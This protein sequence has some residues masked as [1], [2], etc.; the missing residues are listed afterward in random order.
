MGKSFC[1]SSP[2]ITSAAMYDFHDSRVGMPSLGAAQ[3]GGQINQAVAGDGQ[4][5]FLV[6]QQVGFPQGK[7][8]WA[9]QCHNRSGR[10]S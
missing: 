1:T 3:P 7:Q 10:R 2:S 6:A 8:I 5:N 4:G 9:E